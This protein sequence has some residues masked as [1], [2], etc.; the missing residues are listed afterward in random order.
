MIW[1]SGYWQPDFW[2][3]NWEYHYWPFSVDLIL[4]EDDVSAITNSNTYSSETLANYMATASAMD[5]S[6]T[7]V[8]SPYSSITNPVYTGTEG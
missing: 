3:S 7:G 5:E 8:D 4:N 1:T 6:S 2:A